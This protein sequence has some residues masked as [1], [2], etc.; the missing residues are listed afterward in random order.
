MRQEKSNLDNIAHKYRLG[1]KKKKKE[2][3]KELQIK[4]ELDVKK[5]IK[6]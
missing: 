1:R 5:Q 6:Q 4:K 3:G 2:G